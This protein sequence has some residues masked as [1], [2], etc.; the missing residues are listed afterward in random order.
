MTTA[1]PAA[2]T[3]RWARMHIEIDA[4][5]DDLV[6]EGLAQSGDCNR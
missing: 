4:I 5:Q 6:P 1:M 2:R 3:E